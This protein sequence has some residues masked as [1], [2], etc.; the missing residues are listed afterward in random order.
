MK[1]QIDKEFENLIIGYISQ[2]STVEDLKKILKKLKEPKN[3]N[4]FK[5]Y[6]KINFYSIYLMNQSD[7]ES[8]IKE[9]KSRINREE[10]K[11]KRS[12]ILINT[13]R[14]A[15]VFI[16]IFGLGFYSSNN[17]L[18]SDKIQ[19]I[20]LKS[21]DIIL[22]SGNGEVILDKGD[23][24]S[25]DKNIISKINLIQKSNQLI[26]DNNLDIKEIVYHSL[27]VP[28][29]KR[30]NV[31]LTDGSKVFLNS[32]SVL[33]YPIKFLPNQKREVFLQGEAYFDVSK[34]KKDL[35]IVNTNKINVEVYGTKFNVK[36][37]SEDFNSDI[38]LVSGSVAI[39]NNENE[40]STLLKPGFKGS[41]DKTTL[42]ITESKINTKVYTSW[43]EGEVVFRKESFSQI[44][45]KLERLYNVTAIDNRVESSNELFNAAIDVENENIET[46]LE[47][48][49]K[50]YNIKY[51]IFNNKI[52]IN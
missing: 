9:I 31:I 18:P 26:Y 19:K 15:A 21:N 33:K 22:F 29:G 27:K 7:T 8:I 20:I 10:S 44:L 23:N 42:K 41:V 47:Y 49:N 6:I 50:I 25:E 12:H 13:L 43:I 51:E 48:F 35:F 38:V 30:F 46:V 14:Y 5:T 2:E 52:I 28:Y 17:F 11:I 34:N 16:L 4:I 3:S 36:N 1:H 32:G 40:E 37:Y 24:N 39:K 45:K